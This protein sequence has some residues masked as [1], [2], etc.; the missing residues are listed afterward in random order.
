MA[1]E[2]EPPGMRTVSVLVDPTPPTTEAADQVARIAASEIWDCLRLGGRAALWSPGRQT[3]GPAERSSLWALLEW[4]AHYPLLPAGDGD[5]PPS[6]Q[7][8]VIACSIESPVLG[9]LGEL[10][11]SAA[12]ARAWLVDESVGSHDLAVPTETVGTKWPLA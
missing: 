8:I 5:P 9:A 1:R 10:H 6:A 12:Q 3:A 11:L 4:L 7:F 2:Y